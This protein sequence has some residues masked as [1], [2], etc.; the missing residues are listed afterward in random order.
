MDALEKDVSVDLSVDANYNNNEII[1]A[2]VALVAGVAAFMIAGLQAILQYMTSNQRDKCLYGAIGE[3]A[4]YTKTTWD[5]WTWRL[6]VTYAE[7]KIENLTDIIQNQRQYDRYE[8]YKW[9][10]DNEVHK[11]LRSGNEVIKGMY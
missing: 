1:I 7:V 10:I 9:G 2:L 6:R 4:R 11:S 3:W 5:F 8:L